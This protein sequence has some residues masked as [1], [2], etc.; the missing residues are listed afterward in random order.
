VV[1]A[2]VARIVEA[3]VVHP[4][5]TLVVSIGH[6]QSPAQLAEFADGLRANLP[7]SVKVAV[8]G[9]DIQVHVLRTGDAI[10]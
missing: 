7:E 6:A 3:A 5:D 10:S 9:G 8:L 2:E 4:G 1:D